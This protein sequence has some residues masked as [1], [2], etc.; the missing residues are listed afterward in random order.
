[1]T[2]TLDQTDDLLVVDGF[3]PMTLEVSGLDDVAVDCIDKM[4]NYKEMASSNGQLRQGDRIF[5]WQ[6]KN[7]TR[8][9]LGS[10]LVDEDGVDWTILTLRYTPQQATYEAGCRALAV[11]AGLDNYATVLRANAYT[12]NDSGEAV[13]TWTE[14]T[15]DIPARWQPLQEE[16]QVFEDADYTRTTYQVTFGDEPTDNPTELAGSNYR[17]VDTDGNHYRVLEYVQ[18]ERIDKLPYAI[19]VKVLEGAEFNDE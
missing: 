10:V 5:A 8:P 15:S 3:M 11:E 14:I 17:L 7:T 19:V 4:V 16:A 6:S 2:L 18:E 13:P 9:A 12:K 1:M